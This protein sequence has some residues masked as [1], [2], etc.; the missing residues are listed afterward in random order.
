MLSKN[1]WAST[2]DLNTTSPPLSLALRGLL[3]SWKQTFI[4][5]LLFKTKHSV[6]SSERI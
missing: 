2:D 4:W 6:V 3:N 5:D 1:D